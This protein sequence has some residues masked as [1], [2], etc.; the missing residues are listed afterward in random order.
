MAAH[1]AVLGTS[2]GGWTAATACAEPSATQPAGRQAAGDSQ[3][4]L[5]FPSQQQASHLSPVQIAKMSLSGDILGY[6]MSL[7]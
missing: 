6:G 3:P 2:W 5:L 1:A 7:V 4:L